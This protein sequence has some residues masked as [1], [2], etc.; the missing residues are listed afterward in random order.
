MRDTGAETATPARACATEKKGLVSI[1]L[2][3]MS[4]VRSRHSGSSAGVGQGKEAKSS[5]HRTPARSKAP[6][7]PRER[8][9]V[10]SLTD[11]ICRPGNTGNEA[12]SSFQRWR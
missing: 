3:A 1:S 6:I 10:E 5:L 4:L 7:R 11:G 2:R 8:S 9:F 12:S